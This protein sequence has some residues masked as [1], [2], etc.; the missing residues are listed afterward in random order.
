MNLSCT[1]SLVFSCITSCQN[2]DV[3]F[4]D[5]TGNKSRFK[6]AARILVCVLTEKCCSNVSDSTFTRT[7][8]RPTWTWE[9]RRSTKTTPPMETESIRTTTTTTT[10]VAT[11]ATT[12]T[13]STSKPYYPSSQSNAGQAEA[14]SGP[15]KRGR[16]TRPTRPPKPSTFDLVTYFPPLNVEQQ[17]LDN[18]VIKNVIRSTPTTTT[19]TTSTTTTTEMTTTTTTTTT[20]E[21]A[22]IQTPRSPIHMQ[23]PPRLATTLA[24]PP[25]LPSQP[26]AEPRGGC[27]VPVVNK[28]CPKGRIVNGTQSCYGQ[29]PWQ[30]G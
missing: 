26:M 11:T 8:E 14:F 18:D 4:N 3:T 17:H 22:I 28:S 15:A 6:I 7:T 12:T 19:T 27:G 1:V 13:T 29:F 2:K 24:A 23:P 21:W 9:D 16:P 5:V 30:V 20:T 25:P 10:T